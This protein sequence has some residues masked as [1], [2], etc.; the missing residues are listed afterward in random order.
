MNINLTRENKEVLAIFH[1]MQDRRDVVKL[2]EIDKK[3]LNYYIHRVPQN[4]RY[5]EFSISKRNG[6]T[7]TINAPK[8]GLKLIQK[9]LSQALY[10]STNSH[11]NSHGFEHDKS[12]L[13]NATIHTRKKYVLNIDLKDFFTTINFGRVRGL[14]LAKPFSFSEEVATILSQICCHSNSLPQGHQLLQ[15]YLI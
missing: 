4:K 8:A 5:T 14:F 12:I 10:I 9:K 3:I 15:L 11:I 1:S 2:L 6:G 13:T 7:R